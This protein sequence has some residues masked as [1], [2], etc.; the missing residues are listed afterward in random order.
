MDRILDSG[1][2]DWGSTPHGNTK[3]AFT[4]P[5]LLFIDIQIVELRII[6]GQGLLKYY[7][8]GK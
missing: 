5:F 7:I 1:S 6:V 2:N 8:N 4:L 3:A